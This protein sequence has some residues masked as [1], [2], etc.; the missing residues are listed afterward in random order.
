MPDRVWFRSLYWRVAFGFVAFLAAVLIVQGGVLFW[1]I[2]RA[3]DDVAGRSPHDLAALVASDMSATLADSQLIDPGPY[4]REHY[5]DL[6]RP[7]GIV[8]Q[9]G[10]V[11]ASRDGLDLPR[12]FIEMALRRLRAPRGRL[13]GGLRPPIGTPGGTSEGPGSGPEPGVSSG[14]TTPLPSDPDLGP[15]GAGRV[16]GDMM[17]RP[18]AG[19]GMVPGIARRRAMGMAPIVRGGSVVGVVIVPPAAPF[20]AILRQFAPAATGIAVGL[21]LS[22]TTLAAWFVFR[23]AQRRLRA[24]ERA[25]QQLGAGKRDARAPVAGGDEVTAVAR[26]FNAMADE[27]DRRVSELHDATEARRQLLADVSHEL[28]T[29]LT[30]IRG[31]LDTLQMPELQIDDDARRRYLGIVGAE[32]ERLERMIGDLLDLARLEAGG[33]TL[34]VAPVDIDLLFR[35]VVERH[36]REAHE[37]GVTL[38]TSIDPAA[39]TVDG[40]AGRLEQV[41]QNLAANALRHTPA[42]GQVELRSETR[43]GGVAILVRDTGGGLVPEHV[44]R[45]FDRFYKADQARGAD[46]R[47]SGLGLSIVKAIV[48]R[49]G[50]RVSVRSDPGRQTVFEVWLPAPATT[51]AVA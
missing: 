6:S 16:Q 41:L 30:A 33:G 28:M 47:G 27:L 2:A 12:P 25:A 9:D 39:S 29:P 11:I 46:G 7:I 13:P 44:T 1:L 20:P 3:S 24:L 15:G 34:T 36:E 22:A 19:P 38:I 51:A 31:Y 18:G 43:E 21:L 45:I 4:L 35:R 23:P 10:R 32:A 26:A 49:H 50:G 17:G 14:T 48:E 8:M 40:D 5:G 42:G 37:G